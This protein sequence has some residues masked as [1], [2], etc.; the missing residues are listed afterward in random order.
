MT[1]NNT[2]GTRITLHRRF[3]LEASV[4]P[5]L[6]ATQERR[7]AQRIDSARSRLLAALA[8]WPSCIPKLAR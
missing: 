4:I 2:R 7:L 6:S 8:A 1:T 3:T 5:L